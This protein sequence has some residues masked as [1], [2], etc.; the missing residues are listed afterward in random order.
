MRGEGRNGACNAV[1]GNAADL[2]QIV[3]RGQSDQKPALIAQDTSKF[4]GVH[5]GG[6]GKNE[7]E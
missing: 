1:A 3:R 2:H 4:G 5:A 6:D 7:R